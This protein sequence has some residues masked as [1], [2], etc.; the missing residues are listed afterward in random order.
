MDDL[1]EI[2]DQLENLM[3][4]SREISGKIDCEVICTN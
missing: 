4:Q 3:L 2:S 1:S